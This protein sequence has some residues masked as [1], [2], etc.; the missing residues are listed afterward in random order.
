[1]I[2][3]IIKIFVFTYLFIGLA[4]ATLFFWCHSTLDKYQVYKAMEQAGIDRE[5]YRKVYDDFTKQRRNKPYKLF[6]IC[7]LV[8]PYFM[9]TETFKKDKK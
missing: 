5:T 7:V 1:M 6:S 3:T 9:V 8:V 2:L 4:S